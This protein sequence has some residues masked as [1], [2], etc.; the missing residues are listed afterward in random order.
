[1][2]DEREYFERLT[3]VLQTHGFGWVVDQAQ[4][5]ISEGRV[6]S[7]EVSA[8]SIRRA[9]DPDTFLVGQTPRSR[10]AALVATEPFSPTERL[11]ILIH[12]IESAIVT[13]AALEKEVL[14]ADSGFGRI[15][16]RP[17]E[18]DASASV[19]DS[20][21]HRLDRGRLNTTE[22]LQ[23]DLSKALSKLRK[24]IDDGT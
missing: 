20:R 22:R 21:S 6:V 8:P 5:E 2:A 10:R 17:D 14:S 3:E 23:N 12:G 7:K 19:K 24:I 1:M 11:A 13:R 18:T 4:A 15:E 9:Y 16:F